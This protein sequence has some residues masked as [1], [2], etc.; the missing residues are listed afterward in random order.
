MNGS[1]LSNLVAKSLEDIATKNKQAIMQDISSLQKAICSGTDISNA[2]FTFY[3]SA[4]QTGA[5][6]SIKTLSDLGFLDI[7]S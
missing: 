7:S 4:A 3:M 1:E 2:L 6:V 5:A